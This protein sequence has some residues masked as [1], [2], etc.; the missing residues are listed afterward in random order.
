MSSAGHGWR[1][2]G[3]REVEREEEKVCRVVGRAAREGRGIMGS[4]VLWVVIL[5]RGKVG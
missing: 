4:G 5:G 1:L 2:V 3:A